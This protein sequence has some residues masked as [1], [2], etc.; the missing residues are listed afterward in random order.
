MNDPNWRPDFATLLWLSEKYEAFAVEERATGDLE[1]AITFTQIGAI[2][3]AEL[4]TFYE[5]LM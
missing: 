1:T 4:L 3:R 2:A 5:E